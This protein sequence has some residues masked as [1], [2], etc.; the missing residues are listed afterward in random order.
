MTTEHGLVLSTTAPESLVVSPPGS[1]TVVVP[2]NAVASEGGLINASLMS[3]D[4][5]ESGVTSVA[6]SC[7]N[8]SVD[9]VRARLLV[10][11]ISFHLFF[12]A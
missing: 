4:S 8:M 6:Q 1:T 2:L 9:L 5:N 10:L 3:C 11:S 12:V 7:A